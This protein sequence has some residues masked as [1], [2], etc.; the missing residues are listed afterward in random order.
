MTNTY[1][2]FFNIMI[3]FIFSINYLNAQN[4]IYSIPTVVHIIYTDST[5]TN[6]SDTQ[7]YSAINALNDD[8][9]KISGTQGDGAGEDTEIEFCLAQ[10]A[11]DGS[12]T[13]G[14]NRIK[15]VGTC[16]LDYENIGFDNSVNENQVKDLSYWNNEEYYNIW[17]VHKL[18]GDLASEKGYTPKPGGNPSLDGSVIL[19]SAF[20]IGTQFDVLA[21][22]SNSNRTITHHAGH[23]L[24]LLNTYEGDNDGT[25]CPVDISCY[26][27]GDQ[28]CDTS[29][30]IR[31][32]NTCISSTTC[33]GDAPINNYMDNSTEQCKSEF[34]NDQRDRMRYNLE[35]E[36]KCMLLS[37]GCKPPCSSLVS[38]F[39]SGM[40]SG[41]M[42]I[43][44]IFN[45]LSTPASSISDY[46]WHIDC[47]IVSTDE[48]LTHEFNHYGNYE[49][50]LDVI[51]SGSGCQVR[52]C[53]IVN[54]E[55]TI[56]CSAATCEMVDNGDFESITGTPFPPN[57][58]PTESLAIIDDWDS[59]DTGTPWYCHEDSE[60][61]LGGILG[62]GSIVSN[63]LNEYME[64]EISVVPGFNT[65]AISFDYSIQKYLSSSSNQNPINIIVE[66]VGSNGGGGMSFSAMAFIN[67]SFNTNDCDISFNAGSTATENIANY[68]WDFGDG[69]PLVS[70]N[71]PIHT[72]GWEGTFEVCLTMDCGSE[73]KIVCKDVYI[74]GTPDCK[75]CNERIDEFSTQQC[76]N[77]NY[78]SQ[79]VLDIPSGYNLCKDDNQVIWSEGGDINVLSAYIDP[80]NDT[81][82][83]LS[84]EIDPN[85]PNFVSNLPFYI[86]LC[87]SN[88]QTL[89]FNYIGGFSAF[90]C[91][92][93]DTNTIEVT[94]TCDASRS[95][96]D[97]YVYTGSLP[98][99]PPAGFTL[100]DGISPEPS[101]STS[102]EAGFEIDAVNSSSI[103]F[104]ITTEKD[105]PFATSGVLVFCG[106]Q[107]N[108]LVQICFPY[109]IRVNEVCARVRNQNRDTQVLSKLESG[110]T[111]RI[112]NNPSYGILNLEFVE[113]TKNGG[114]ILLLNSA[115]IEV[116][117]EIIN[118]GIQNLIIATDNLPNGLYFVSYKQRNGS[119]ETKKVILLK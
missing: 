68:S 4:D 100:C 86:T 13:T 66:I 61:H 55:P 41:N 91:R 115:G 82:L 49:I 32:D 75:N 38:D 12:T 109:E 94:A 18:S 22:E 2:F 111:F 116:K 34:T 98:I 110:N 40:T 97:E 37:L 63:P 33:G 85:D 77:D 35:G 56:D 52:N 19:Y 14:I 11:P 102:S 45:N 70:G 114:S 99:A 105:H 53:Q 79:L 16:S 39:D 58:S 21:A 119:L 27:D 42:P 24:N 25:L 106:M 112:L 80:D 78:Y 43:T 89:C 72:F 73:E 60:T 26:T 44:T 118:E 108:E 69:S 23:F 20:G 76:N 90:E 3:A 107:G 47:E 103:D 7:V 50:C 104:S 74:D 64:S 29:P 81:K 65:Y 46:I 17:I 95:G 59:A 92:N 5:D 30:H 57:T 8:F 67:F 10:R 93:C 71:N 31:S 1:K 87:D 9:R 83:N 28:C 113:L 15:C 48:D 101:G 117:S 6:I 62:E 96:Q 51:D 84:V 54:V 88:G 36:R